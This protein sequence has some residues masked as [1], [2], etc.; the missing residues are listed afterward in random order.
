MISFPRRGLERIGS[1]SKALNV[2]ARHF[3]TS[4]ADVMSS[5]V[6]AAVVQLTCTADKAANFERAA[7]LIE[8]AK[9][10][11]NASMVFLPEAFDFIG[12]SASQSKLLAEPIDGPTVTAYCALATSLDVDLSL[13]GLHEK[14]R[15]GDR[16]RNTH[17]YIRGGRVQSVYSKCHLFDVDI[18]EKGVKLRESDYVEPGH[19]ILAPVEAAGG[20]RIGLG[21]CYD[22]RFPEMSLALVRKGANVITYPSAFTVPT[23]QAHWESLLRAR[24]IECQ[25]YV[26]AA[27]QVGKHN[28]KRSSYGHSMIV[29]PWGKVIAK[30]EEGEG[31]ASA[32]LDL[33]KIS[34]IR[35]EMPVR[36]HRRPD[37]YGLVTLNNCAV[38]SQNESNSDGFQFGPHHIPCNHVVFA[39]EYTYVMVNRKPVLP[40]HLL[41]VPKL[42][43]SK[44]L[45]DLNCQENADFFRCVS[46]AQ[47][48]AE[49][50]TESSSST[51]SIQDGPNAG[52]TVDH[53]HCHVLARRPGDFE[54]NDEIYDKLGSHDH[55]PNATEGL[56]TPAQMQEE[57]AFLREKARAILPK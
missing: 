2:S 25:S 15:S 39:S 23:G 48:L 38:L 49:H 46:L 8:T 51:V 31:V 34:K 30:I 11:H 6:V 3:R 1:I 10:E 47:S 55:G 27:A 13:G 54:D 35:Q 44:R 26:V 17:V 28:S 45:K 57:A 53:L 29:D 56:R 19:A 20:L 21:I 43:S 5:S 42:T 12:E 52:Q 4:R 36:E 16:V 9:R 14:T 37:L 32:N 33:A 41:V 50:V 40:Y 22:L 7:K 18:P 24:A